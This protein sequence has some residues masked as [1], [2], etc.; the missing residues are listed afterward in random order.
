[1]LLRQRVKHGE[2]WRGA[3]PGADQQHG[4]I[5]P[6]EDEGAARG[7]DVELVADGEPGVQVA[8]G[9]AVGF[10]LDGDPVVAGVGRSAE[11]VVA[12][13]RPPLRVGLDP[14]REVLTRAG[15]WQCRAVGVL[16]AYGDHRV[17]F[18]GD[19]GD[20][21]LTEAGPGGRRAGYRET[22]VAAAGFFLEQSSERG[23]PAG[24]EG[25]D[26]E[27]AQQL[28]ARVPGEIQQRVDLRDP[29]LFRARGELDDLVS[30]LY[31]A[32][33]KHAEVEARAVVRDEHRG[34]A[35]VVHADPDAVAGDPG[36]RDLEDGIADLVAIADAHLVIGESFH[37]EVL[38]ELAV[39]EVVSSE[40]ALP[41]PIGVDLVNEHCALLPAV[42]G[43][44]ALTITLDVELLGRGEGRPR[45]P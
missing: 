28:L 16:D 18:A 10:A 7:C 4:C 31:V 42:P 25:R 33:F 38:A 2:D 24:A 43:E 35:R 45:G 14:H 32:F 27:R 15:G 37:G 6:V 19:C 11:G 34:D 22:G 36:L 41:V 26:P 8:A 23:L 40:L 44:I 5:R 30:R 21:Q 12:E 1:M 13:H 17:A 20:G 3:D 9:G 39:H 29:H